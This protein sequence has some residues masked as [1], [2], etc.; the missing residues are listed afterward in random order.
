MGIVNV[1]PDSFSDGG[2]WFDAGRAIEHGLALAAE[3]AD[4]LDI[5][6]VSTRPGASAV[7][8]AEELRRVLPVIQGLARQ[9]QIP[10]SIDTFR[11][12]IA[13]EAIEAG[14]SIVNDV[15]QFD[16]DAAMA[17]VVRETGAGVVL[18][19]SRPTHDDTHYADVVEDVKAALES[20]LAYAREHGI[21]DEACVID[22]GLGFAK[23][24]AHNVALLQKLDCL[25]PLAPVLIGASRKRFIGELGRATASRLAAGGRASSRAEGRATASPPSHPNTRL[26]GSVAVAVWSALHGASII[27]AHDVKETVEALRVVGAIEGD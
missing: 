8:E 11:A 21:A 14:A 25:T 7:D 13:R 20:A 19:H 9:T 4:M 12:T 2:Q 6:G 1:T 24:T 27:R 23:D 18:T 22:P 26:G 3:G 15:A 16:G 5:G 10:L 17:A